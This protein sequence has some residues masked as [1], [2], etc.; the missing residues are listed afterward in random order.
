MGI[1][2]IEPT[3]VAVGKGITPSTSC[4]AGCNAS[5]EPTAVA[6]GKFDA[7]VAAGL[8]RPASIEPTAVAVGKRRERQ[9]PFPSAPFRF[10]RADGRS[11]R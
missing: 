3:A 9:A 8:A 1:A 11:R 10:N 5:I 2:S 7:D 4:C 6:V